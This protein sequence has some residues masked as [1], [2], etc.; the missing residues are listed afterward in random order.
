MSPHLLDRFVQ[1]TSEERFR[2]WFTVADARELGDRL[3]DLAEVVIDPEH[4]PA[5]VEDDPSDDYLVALARHAD[6][7]RLL[8]GDHGIRRAL[9][10]DADL[11]VVSP[12]ELLD[13]LA[14]QADDSNP[15]GERAARRTCLA[16][17]ANAAQCPPA[18]HTEH[19]PR[20]VGWNSGG[21]G[22]T[23]RSV[24]TRVAKGSG[25]P[26]LNLPVSAARRGRSPSGPHGPGNGDRQ[27]W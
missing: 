27:D 12:A 20:W 9:V 19:G 2:R 17:A 6:A 3:S 11:N 22:P 23:S 14:S 26:R 8:T 10:H 18:S 5:A 4:I 16:P 13:E 7:Q 21:S 15:P 24:G 25:D 1:R